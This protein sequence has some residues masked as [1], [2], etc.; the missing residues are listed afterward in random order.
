M[1]MKYF[2]LFF[3]LFISAET[4]AQNVPSSPHVVDS[5]QMEEEKI[6]TKTENPVTYPGGEKKLFTYIESNLDKQSIFSAGASKG[7]YIIMLRFIVRQDSVA[8]DFFGESLTY[9]IEDE[10]IRILKT[11]PKW[12]PAKQNGRKVT[13]YYRMKFSLNLK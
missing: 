9:N 13:A 3:T 4:Y 11:I 5:T 12:N 8:Y 7:N 1:V 6:F 2:F 10:I